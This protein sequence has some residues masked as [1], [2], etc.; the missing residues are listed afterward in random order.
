MRAKSPSVR[1]IG[2]VLAV[3][4]LLSPTW[5]MASRAPLTMAQTQSE[6]SPFANADQQI[7][8]SSVSQA[9]SPSLTEV[10]LQNATAAVGGSVHSC[11]LTSEGGVKCWGHNNLGQLGDGTTTNRLAPV[12][13]SGLSNGVAAISAGAEHSCALTASGGVK[14][15][16]GNYGGQLGD[17][18]TTDRLIPVDVVG[19]T[20][21]VIAIAA[22]QEHTCALTSTGGVKCWGYNF[23]GELGDGTT[24]NRLT[25]VDVSGLTSGAAAISTH[26]GNHTCAVTGAGAAKCWGWNNYGQLGDATTVNRNTPVDVVGLSSGV[27]SIYNGYQHTFAL[28]SNGTLKCWGDN[29]NGRLGDGTTT[30]RLTPV[31]VSGLTSGVIAAGAG[32]AHAC[33]IVQGG[34]VECW[35]FNA[36]GQV[37]DGTTIE[38][39]TPTAVS[40]LSSGI[41]A[42]D[43]GDNHT[44]ALISGGIKCW[45]E[46]SYGQLGD[47]TTNSSPTPVDVVGLGGGPTYFISGRVTDGNSS[48]ISD[49]VV[50]TAPGRSAVT[51]ASGYYTLTGFV[52]GTYTLTPHKTGYAF[53]PGTRM[54]RVPSAIGQ[55]FTGF[56]ATWSSKAPMPAPRDSA[57]AVALDGKVY[58]IG[59]TDSTGALASMLMYDPVENSW[60]SKASMPDVK[61]GPGAAV[62]NGRIYVVGPSDPDLYEY[63]PVGDT[64]AIK[65]SLPITPSAKVALAALGGQVYV[66]FGIAGDEHYQLYRYNLSN[67]TWQQR[68]SHPDS[69]T[70]ASLGVANG[71]IYAV[72]GGIQ[73]QVPMETNRVDRY[74][75]LNNTWAT[76]VTPHL[77]TSR[78]HLGPILP[79]VG[80]R[81]YVFGGWDGYS[82]LN[83]VEVY[84]PSSN[85]WALE[86][87]MLTARYKAAYA[88][89]GYKV[90]VIGGNQGGVSDN[91][92]ATNEELALPQLPSVVTVLDTNGTVQAG[93]PVYAFS[94]STYTGYNKTTDAR[95]Q[96]AFTLPQGEYRFRVDKN[97][98]QFWSGES[99]HC[100]VPGCT[101]VV[102]TVT[103]PLAVTVLDTEGTAQVGMSVYAFDGVTYM[104]YHKTTDANGQAVFTLPQ[105]N[106]RF[107]A[108]KNST[109]FWSGPDNHCPIPGCSSTAVTVSVPVAVT[110]QDS[111]GVPEAGL[112]V[113]AFDGNTYTN[114]GGTTNVG[115]QVT[116]TLPLGSYRFRSDKNGTQFW[117]G[118]SN[119]CTVPGCTAATIRTSL[120]TIVT[121]QDA[122]STPEAGLPVYTFDANTYIGSNGTTNASGQV[123]FTLPAG[124]YR[125]RADKNGTQFWSGSSNHCTVPGCTSATITT[126][127]LTVVTVRDANGTPEGGLPV[128]AF[129]GSTYTNY[130]GTTNASGQ[131]TFTLP[132]GN[133]RFRTDKNGTQ[134]WSGA[135]NH[136]AVPGCTSAA[137]TV[138]V[139][140]V[141]MVQD[142][143]GA[144]GIGLPV[145][146][147]SGTTYMNYNGTTNATGQVT[148]TLPLGG[149][150]FRADKNGTQFWSNAANHCPIPG[151]TSVVVTVSVPVVVAVRDT[152]SAPG[153]GLPVYAFSG[154]TYMNYNGTTNADGQ[155][156]LTLPL[157]SYRFRADKNGTQFWSGASNHCAVPG[158]VSTVVTVSVPVVIKVQDSTGAPQASVPVYAFDGGTYTNYNGTTNASGQV[159]LTLPLGNYR[160]RADE[161]GTQYWSGPSNH[162]TV[163]SCTTVTVTVIA[164]GASN[165]GNTL[166]QTHLPVNDPFPL[167]LA[168]LVVS[169]LSGRKGKQQRC[170]EMFE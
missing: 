112:P 138:S 27:I 122:N 163:P 76:D 72:G 82:T 22:G 25:P 120:L 137:I 155:V 143:N 145:Y 162:C 151:C 53:S 136:C 126:S 51:S 146:A 14:C 88:P 140:V 11:A 158:C 24:T 6:G 81:M 130:N 124:N 57:A 123:T 108:D 127:L 35:G 128:Y 104:G 113:Y 149:Y 28:V 47:G 117:S 141:V 119:H 100:A 118:T 42:I 132:T 170:Y 66:A 115:G 107:R 133:Y 79:T 86:Q 20:T 60:T 44:C 144:P 85:T 87:P 16:G 116:L 78:T 165:S 13:V 84:D 106:Y 10:T 1:V 148:L 56:L 134:F 96:V 90:Y 4:V 36:Y 15:W 73:G 102:V 54:V 41:A 50:S 48:P 156:T 40:G 111:N 159:T 31:N 5:V 62:E 94:G 64:W 105:G 103:V 121:V 37:G 135:S 167:F 89:I 95:G 38:R 157:G 98:T 164:G 21:G 3:A 150:R 58:V 80:G 160:F 168:P 169:A 18:T 99:D 83:S 23:A 93:L 55:D 131:Y 139:P 33:A 7:T 61:S 39:H 153:I 71:L 69:R 26:R 45:G 17:G 63:N 30:T 49:V 52:T 75:P 9:S 114:Y 34:G 101:S 97:G 59:G 65:A 67:D 161:S 68:A 109:Q 152:D 77:A 110:V 43:G 92:L 91:W 46:N 154:T 166:A 74:D 12:D 125:F 129:D 29:G 8:S 32:A 19:L 2:C 142:T 147:F 70:I